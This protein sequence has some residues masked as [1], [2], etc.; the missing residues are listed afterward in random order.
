MLQFVGLLYQIL[1]HRRK[2]QQL[3]SFDGCLGDP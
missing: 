3:S 2:V 1:R